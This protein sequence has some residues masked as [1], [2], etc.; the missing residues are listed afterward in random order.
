[1]SEFENMP[2]EA[3]KKRGGWPKGKPRPMKPTPEQVTA[4]ADRA[5]APP[6]NPMIAKMKARP[7]WDSDDFV[8]VG[9]EG[10]DRLRIPPETIQALWQDG[11]ALQWATRSVRGMET[12]QELGKMTRGGWTPV[13]QSDFGGILDGMFMSKGLDDFPI[14]VEDCLLVARPADLQKRAK[15]GMDR[16]AV[17][18][19]QIAEEQIG[20]GI[21]GV[22]G[23]NLKNKGVRNA[24]NKTTERIE[25]PDE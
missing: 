4:A 10:V 15:K 25:I 8:G 17:M 18:P 14:A 6:R 5:A 24:I 3:P 2:G 9:V 12:P 11:I 19:L 16:D 7:N 13:H 23:S 20:H 21:P 1:M 22:T